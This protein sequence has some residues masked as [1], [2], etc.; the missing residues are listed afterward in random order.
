[1]FAEILAPRSTSLKSQHVNTIQI[2]NQWKCRTRSSHGHPR[3][4]VVRSNGMLL[5]FFKTCETKPRQ[6]VAAWNKIRN[7]ICWSKIPYG[8]EFVVIADLIIEDWHD[9]E[10]CVASDVHV[11]RIES[12]EVRIKKLQEVFDGA[13][14][15]T[16]HSRYY[17]GIHYEL[18]ITQHN[19]SFGG[20][21]D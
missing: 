5:L 4:V 6:I 8:A 21:C 18:K 10:N 1:M 7:F 12:N 17:F 15:I 2:R 3:N 16:W 19:R 14:K 13:A 11:K 9:I 20:I